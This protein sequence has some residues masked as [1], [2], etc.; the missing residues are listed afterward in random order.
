MVVLCPLPCNAK[1]G[2]G[3]PP[4]V[5]KSAKSGSSVQ[6]SISKLVLQPGVRAIQVLQRSSQLL[7]FLVVVP[8]KAHDAVET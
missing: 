8:N 4:G 3:F 2:T 7:V 6:I 5:K 1:A